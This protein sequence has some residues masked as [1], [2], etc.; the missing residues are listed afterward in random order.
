M[1]VCLDD[2]HDSH[3]VGL[4]G[5]AL[6]VSL[7]LDI[8]AQYRGDARDPG[9]AKFSDCS[10]GAS[11]SLTLKLTNRST[12]LPATVQFRRIAHFSCQPARK[13][14]QAGQSVDVTVTFAPRQMGLCC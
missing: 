1:A 4:T 6:P 9:A 13:C 5:V 3:E 8:P 14:L 2:S 11:T 7:D 12:D 10:V